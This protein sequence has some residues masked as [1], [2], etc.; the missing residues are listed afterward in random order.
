MMRKTIT[1]RRK[2]LE[3]VKALKEKL[4]ERTYSGVLVGSV[5]ILDRLLLSLEEEWRTL[6]DRYGEFIPLEPT[7]EMLED[8]AVHLSFVA[9]GKERPLGSEFLFEFGKRLAEKLG[10]PEEA[11]KMGRRVN[12]EYWSR[13]SCRQE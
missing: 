8:Y 10:R 6:C 7:F 5:E 13:Y 12:D 3:K 2:Q 11:E 1:L 9:R 4:G